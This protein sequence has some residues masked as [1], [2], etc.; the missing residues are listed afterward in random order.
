MHPSFHQNSSGNGSR[1]DSTSR[2]SSSYC[3]LDLSTGEC[4]RE[5]GTDSGS[6]QCLET[7]G[8]T[9]RCAAGTSGDPVISNHCSRDGHG[10]GEAG[11]RGS[12]SRRCFGAATSRGCRGS[13]PGRGSRW[14][15][16]ASRSVQHAVTVRGHSGAEGDVKEKSKKLEGEKVSKQEEE[17]QE[18][19]EIQE[20][21]KEGLLFEPQLV[22]LQV[23]FHQEQQIQFEQQLGPSEMEGQGKVPEAGLRRGAC[24]GCPEVQKERRTSG[25][26]DETSRS[27]EC[28]LFG[29]N[30]CQI[31]KGTDDK[32]FPTQGGECCSVGQPAFRLDRDPRCSRSSDSGRSDGLHQ[33]T[34]DLKG[35]GRVGTAHSCHP[36]GQTKGRQLGKS[37]VHRVDTVGKCL[38]QL[39]HAGSHQL[40]GRF[41]KAVARW[42]G[43]NGAP[44]SGTQFLCMVFT[45]VEQIFAHSGS[46]HSFG[47]YLWNLGASQSKLKRNLE[48]GVGFRKDHDRGYSL[49]HVFPLPPMINKG[50]V[51]KYDMGDLSAGDHLLVARGCNIVQALL[52]MLYGGC[53]GRSTFVTAAQHRVQTRLRSG[54]E[55]M[56][57]DFKPQDLGEIQEFLKHSRHY[58]GGGVAIPLGERGGVPASAATVDLQSLF[59]HDHPQFAQ[60][61]MEPS[62]LLLPSRLRPRRVKRGHTWLH[63]SYPMLVRKNVK[64]GLHVLKRES[65]V[66]KHRGV[67]CLTGAFAVPKDIDEDRVI[68]DPSVNQLIDPLKLPRPRFAYIPKLRV[69]MVPKSGKILVSKRDARHYFHSLQVG[70]KWQKWLCGPPIVLDN[71]QRRY[72]ASRTAPMGFGPSAGWAQQV[73]DMAT[74]DSHMPAERRLHPDRFAPSELPIWGSICDDI[75]A[76]EHAG[77]ND[78]PLVGPRWLGDAEEAWKG[79]GVH[80]NSKKSVN[81]EPGHEVQGVYVDPDEHWVGVSMAKRQSLFQATFHILAQHTVLLGDVERLVGKFGYSHACRPVMRSVFDVTYGWLEKQRQSKTRRIQIPDDVW[82]EIF[83]AAMLLPYCQFN[84]SAPFSSRVECTDASMTGLGRAWA[85]MPPDLVQLMAQLSDHN[86]V[87]TNLSLPYGIGL[88]EEHTC[89]LRRLQLPRDRFHWHKIGAP[90][91]PRYIFLGEA[92]AALW[93]AEDRLRRPVDDG[94]RFVHPMDSASCVGAFCKGRSASHLLNVRCQRM[95]AICTAGGHE[96]FYPW[97][98]SGDNPA[99]EP[100]RRFEDE[101]HQIE[102]SSSNIT[103]TLHS[104]QQLA[105]DDLPAIETVMLDPFTLKGW[106]GGE[107]VFVH[108]CSG[109]SRDDDLVSWVERL[110]SDQGFHLVG[111]RVDPLCAWAE[112]VVQD[113]FHCHD[114]LNMEHGHTLLRLFHSRR[115]VGVFASPPRSTFSAARHRRLKPGTCGP[116]PLRSRADVWRP[117]KNLRPKEVLAVAI[118]SVL[119][120]LCIGLLG[121]GRM[122]GAWVGFEHP[123][124]RGRDPFPSVFHSVEMKILKQI[125]GLS[126]FRVDQCMFGAFT[127]KPT[128]LVLPKACSSVVR[129]C[130]HPFKHEQL[131]GF[132]PIT[133]EFR[134][135]AT[136]K[137]PSGFSHELARQFVERLRHAHTHG[138]QCPY[139][140][141][142]NALDQHMGVDPWA[143][144]VSTAWKWPSPSRTF[145][146]ECLER[147]HQGKVSASDRPAQS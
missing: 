21:E 10:L 30:L 13:R 94:C 42:Q 103:S 55:S 43:R 141:R 28:P 70:K 64:T 62:A 126:Y 134:T 57:V 6:D 89:P 73:T 138:Y 3:Q 77:R 1:Q 140:P 50:K 69:V 60:Q 116:R 106:A 112:N 31:V 107:K 18:G 47:Q 127:K 90:S 41:R 53:G 114:L 66:A 68:T 8:T 92:D 100:S 87:Y 113:Q 17:V 84:L 104:S 76:L 7:G 99:D 71:G 45:S 120:L 24:R 38:S 130:N 143:G 33:Q 110:A 67:L 82:T 32:K 109:A 56:M 20:E 146:A 26:C 118:E 4:Q 147:C 11:S 34:G 22:G 95:C 105:S 102:G 2:D 78:Q 101:A 81:A 58:A 91:R 144:A 74:D 123:R 49:Q 12:R 133:S 86:G 137:Y 88:T 83:M 72:P 15:A 44:V 108:L 125:F 135:T 93:C 40:A 142:L 128:G 59:Q 52:N 79:Y 75:W 29:V 37:R 9:L 124:D 39:E 136:A 25:L 16:S 46:V 5:V 111:L 80:P 35:N 85:T 48:F 51:E 119:A 145:F 19:Q 131:S 115:V 129:C 98:P 54:W 61:V 117:F 122:F 63:K 132:N 121:E 97:V 14:R 96:V 36:A 139:A 27:S 23:P 65:Q